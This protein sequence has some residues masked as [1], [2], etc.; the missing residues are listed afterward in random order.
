[1]QPLSTNTDLANLKF[2]LEEQF[3]CPLFDHNGLRTPSFFVGGQVIEKPTKRNRAITL[4]PARH[5]DEPCHV[6]KCALSMR[7][8]CEQRV[9]TGPLK[10]HPH[11]LRDGTLV[12]LSMKIGQAPKCF[13]YGLK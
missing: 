8:T 9:R 5:L 13:E 2:P 1:M 6:A 12:S 7:P 11:G 10:K 4:E 3:F